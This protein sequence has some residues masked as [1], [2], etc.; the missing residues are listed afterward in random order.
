MEELQAALVSRANRKA[1]LLWEVILNSCS[2]KSLT[3]TVPSDQQFL[4]NLK[5][6]TAFAVTFM[7]DYG[8]HFASARMTDIFLVYYANFL[9]SAAEALKI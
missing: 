7:M 5:T 3:E 8:V 6:I 2:C 4:G 9:A 1:R